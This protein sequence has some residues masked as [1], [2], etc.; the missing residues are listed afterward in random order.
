[1][2][3]EKITKSSN[4]V[5][6]LVASARNESQDSKLLD[7]ANA[8]VKELASDLSPDHKYKIAQIVGFTVN[9]MI[10]PA[11]DWLAQLA[12]VKNVGYGDK[13]QF[14]TPLNG[15]K[16]FVQAKGST[17]A[18]SKVASKA[19]TLDTVEISARPV[20][21]IVELLSGQTDMAELIRKATY[22]ME[23]AE[24]KLV[25]D[26]LTAA[27]TNWASPYYASG[28]GIVKATLDPMIR[29]WMR[30]SAGATPVLLGDIDIIA[31]LSEQTGFTAAT[32][33]QQFADGII[34]EH[35]MNGFI[36][37]YSGA[38]VANMINPVKDD[39]TLTFDHD[40]LFILPA[41]VDASMRPLKVV[42]EGDVIS[43]EETNIDDKSYEV[44]LDRYVGA[45][46]IVG[47]R[48]YLSVYED[49]TL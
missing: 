22:E 4:L 34:N 14:K 2:N 6:V 42:H 43:Q 37:V 36:G 15:I 23:L 17:T 1:M 30:M 19:I 44:R 8:Y 47:D 29:H 48:P 16:A 5:K 20:I 3:E 31:K 7:E 13:A 12:D 28:S 9:E 39:D 46:V 38:R 35:N 11:T 25:Q 26:A 18:R 41:G 33:T 49:L 24:Y 32:G 40:K 45:G 10:K 27:A 21:N